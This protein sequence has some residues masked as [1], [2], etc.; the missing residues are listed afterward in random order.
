MPETVLQRRFH[1]HR[2]LRLSHR[3]PPGQSTRGLRRHQSTEHLLLWH[4]LLHRFV[5]YD[6]GAEGGVLYYWRDT[7][8][9]LFVRCADVYFW[10]EMQELDEP[11]R[12]FPGCYEG[13]RRT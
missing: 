6:S 3:L 9:Y 4:E 11:G 8:L 12:L 1:Q 13:V 7:R 5:D 2:S 10:E